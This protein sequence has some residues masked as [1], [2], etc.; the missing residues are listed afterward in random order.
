MSL[1]VSGEAPVRVARIITR[2]NIGGPSVQAI[3]LSR[4]LVPRGFETCLIHGRLAAGEGD[5][6]QWLSITAARTVYVNDLVRPLTPLRDL[7]A[8]WAI[9][10]ALLDWQPDIVHTHMAKAG[11]LG[12]LAGLAYNWTPGRG[13]RARLIHTYHGHVFEGYFSPAFARVFVFIERFLARCSDALIA[14]S[15]RVHADLLD[16]YR[17]AGRDQLKIIPLG[18]K[19]DR[20]VALTAADRAAA[21]RTLQ[22]PED[23]IVVGTVGR[24]TAIKHQALF[25]EMAR[26][27]AGQSPRYV[28]LI[29]GDGELRPELERRVARDGLGARARFLGWRGDLDVVYG[30]MDIFALTSKNEGTPVSLIEAMAAGVATVATDVGGVRDVISSADLGVLVPPDNIDALVSA[31]ARLAADALKRHQIGCQARMDMQRRF[32]GRRLAGQVTE[33]YS[34]VLSR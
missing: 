20:L 10:K 27:L 9:Y 19:L 7:R 15:P 5:I 21:R 31:V 26:I 13:P 25:V 11:A 33:L 32:D 34:E 6:T 3:D 8:L 1:Q 17:I 14:I 16:R 2:L 30:A 18:F 24:L 22:I 4:E 28:F 29:A 23:A 12:R